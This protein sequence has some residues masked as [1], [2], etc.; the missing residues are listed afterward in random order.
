MFITL[1]L[2]NTK[3]ALSP[4]SLQACHCKSL[5]EIHFSP[6]KDTNYFLLNYINVYEAES[7]NAG[8]QWNNISLKLYFFTD[9]RRAFSLDREARYIFDK[10]IF[11]IHLLILG[12]CLIARSYKVQGKFKLLCHNF[13]VH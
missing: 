8:G 12:M 1:G 11:K 6:R 4:S 10:C 3:Y 9:N 13:V 2:I 5:L 7:I